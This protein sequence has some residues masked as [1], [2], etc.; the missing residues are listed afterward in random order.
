MCTYLAKRGATYYFD[1][2]FPLS[3]GLLSAVGQSLCCRYGPRIGLGQSYVS[4]LIL[5]RRTGILTDAAR[6]LAGRPKPQP[7]PPRSAAQIERDRRQWDYDQQQADDVADEL[8]AADMEAERLGPVMDAL[9]EG[10][11]PEGSLADIAK[12]GRL[13]VKN[14]REKAGADREALVWLFWTKP[15]RP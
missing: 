2:P 7:T 8:F 3:F 10:I 11:E 4:L 14:E 6:S 12:A 5:S 9:G 13:L 15:M 1:G